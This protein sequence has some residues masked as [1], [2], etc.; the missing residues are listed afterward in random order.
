MWTGWPTCSGTNLLLARRLERPAADPVDPA[1]THPERESGVGAGLVL[2][3]REGGPDRDRGENRPIDL[4]QPRERV[5]DTDS[6]FGLESRR[7]RL[8]ALDPS[9]DR[10]ERQPQIPILVFPD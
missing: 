2:G 3:H 8:I 9:P 4:P 10:R 7:A 6:R 5:A 1:I